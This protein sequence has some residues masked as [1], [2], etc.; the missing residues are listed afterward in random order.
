MPRPSLPLSPGHSRRATLRNAP[1]A[2]VLVVV[3]VLVLENFRTAEDETAGFKL[4]AAR[5]ASGGRAGGRGY[6]RLLLALDGPGNQAG[7]RPCARPAQQQNGK[8]GYDHHQRDSPK[9]KVPVISEG[10]AWNGDGARRSRG[11]SGRWWRGGRGGGWGRRSRSGRSRWGW[12]R[13]CLGCLHDFRLRHWRRHGRRGRRR[14]QMEWGGVRR[15]RC[16][17]RLCELGWLRR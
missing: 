15:D 16:V 8:P 6:S 11:R 7:L 13:F 3:L 14:R 4:V 2:L 10:F 5:S 17:W 12:G 1:S 9:P